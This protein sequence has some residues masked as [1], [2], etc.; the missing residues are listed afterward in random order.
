M[1][2]AQCIDALRGETL[3]GQESTTLAAGWQVFLPC[4]PVIRLAIR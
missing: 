2:A 4:V 3:H 1:A